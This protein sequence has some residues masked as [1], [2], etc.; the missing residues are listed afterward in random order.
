ME[1]S[2]ATVELPV[3]METSPDDPLVDTPVE[4]TKSPELE[5]VDAPVAIVTEPE[6]PVVLSPVATS[7]D[8][9]DA[10]PWP[11]F[12]STAPPAPPEAVAAPASSDTVPPV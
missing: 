2:P 7:N 5:D 8:P 10:V 9:D 12:I 3:E 4:S 6:A 11:E 1:M